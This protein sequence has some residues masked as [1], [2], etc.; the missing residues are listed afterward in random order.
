MQQAKFVGEGIMAEQTKPIPFWIAFLCHF[1]YFVFFA[2]GYLKDAFSKNDKLLFRTF[3]AFYTR[4]VYRR[5]CHVFNM[6]ISSMAG[7]EIDVVDRVS[8]DYNMTFRMPG[9]VTK[10]IN[11]GSYNYLGFAENSGPRTESV[12]V[13]IKKLGIGVCSTRHE[14]GSFEI[15]RILEKKVAKFL[16]VEDSIVFGM[17]FATNSTNIPALAGKGCLIFSDE[18]NHASMILGCRLSGATIRV[19]KH[20]DVRDLE[21]KIRAAIIDGQPRSRRPWRK[22]VIFV[23]GIYSMEGTIC[24]LPD[25]IALKKKYK[26]YL[27][28]DEAHSIGAMGPSGRGIVDYYDCDAKDVDILMGTFTKSF[29]A[30]G[31][32]IAG[33]KQLIDHIRVQSHSTIYA[34]SMSA[35]VA[36]Q[37]IAVL[38]ALDGPV[39]KERVARLARNTQYFRKKLNQLGFVVH[40]HKDSPVVPLLLYFP[41]KIVAFVQTALEKGVATVGAGFPATP[42]I[43]SRVRFCLSASHTQEMLDKALEV[44][45]EIGDKIRIKYSHSD[46]HIHNCD[47]E[48][49]Y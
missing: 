7:A 14:L 11:M 25:L 9:T 36:Q 5:I 35:A 6:P 23:E 47:E 42:L 28:L 41:V 19:F 40:G 32:Y 3:D 13:T 15:H 17:G 27:Y 45:S 33:T 16:D 20:N 22:I 49:H 10:A 1:S 21:R 30:A 34:T 2:F 29:G 24:P 12:E 31:G 39:G 43:E 37:V 26:A 46:M 8:D 38:E 18:Y 44:T 48:V 4:H